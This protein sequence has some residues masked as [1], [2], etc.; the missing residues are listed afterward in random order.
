MVFTKR[1]VLP[2]LVSLL[3]GGVS[4]SGDEA[5]SASEE[6]AKIVEAK[7]T[8]TPTPELIQLPSVIIVE[9]PLLDSPGGS[10]EIAAFKVGSTCTYLGVTK[11]V[12]D[13]EKG[14]RQY[15][16]VE[17]EDDYTGWISADIVALNAHTAVLIEDIPYVG[18]QG[19]EIEGSILSK[20]QFIAVH[21]SKDAGM[22]DYYVA[23]RAPQDLQWGGEDIFLVKKTSVSLNMDDIEVVQLYKN[24]LDLVPDNA[25]NEE[26]I[27]GLE[28]KRKHLETILKIHDDSLLA[29][30]VYEEFVATEDELDWMLMQQFE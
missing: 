7:P 19:T 11:E 24:A 8:P 26:V 30:F 6:P 2:V 3:L 1:I 27:K 9:G 25:T 17:N 21:P 13:P 5:G 12:E 14:P 16:Y 22:D 20:I 15:C 28:I 18:I 23:T 10:I 29:P 4:C